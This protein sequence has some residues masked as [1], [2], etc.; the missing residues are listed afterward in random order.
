M[1]DYLAQG[2][3]REYNVIDLTICTKFQAM[4]TSL[5]RAKS[6]ANTLILRDFDSSIMA[7]EL[8]GSLRQEYCELNYLDVIT[9]LRYRG[10][11]PDHII[12]PMRWATIAR[13]K[14]WRG[15]SI[16]EEWHPAIQGAN[17][18][19]K[20][21]DLV[22]NTDLDPIKWPM[23]R[24]APKCPDDAAKK[25]RSNKTLNP[26]L[27]AQV[28]EYPVGPLWDR[29][30][31]SCAFDAWT[32]MLYAIR[33]EQ[34][35]M[36]MEGLKSYGDSLAHLVSE[37]NAMPRV[38]PESE[39]ILLRNS[40]RAELRRLYPGKYGTRGVEMTGLA[41]DVLSMADRDWID[42]APCIACLNDSRPAQR[43][44]DH[45]N[46]VEHDDRVQDYVTRIEGNHCIECE[47]G[48]ARILGELI[49]F[50]VN[51]RPRIQLDARLDL[52][53]SGHYCLAGV[54]YFGSFHFT[55]R[56]ITKAGKIYS[57]D[58]MDGTYSVYNGCLDEER[59]TFP[60]EDLKLCGDKRALIAV[61][62]RDA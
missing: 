38:D 6:L 34:G 10:I 28:W 44:L 31:Y 7:R 49:C 23:K 12:Q 52:E 15:T 62:V 35:Q 37:M 13:Y 25:K 58:G 53:Y 26:R 32:F 51:G 29:N 48:R 50:E 46:S 11:L 42:D 33:E 57:H 17:E 36:W 59:G 22:V 19:D 43:C 20:T 56:A 9:D 40:W 27:T 55:V 45:Y 16:K 2:K 5:S 1:T 14:A 47:G 41:R 60:V 4:Y 54:I 21:D 8:D 30:D 18:L 24:K 61:Y 39:M 3:T